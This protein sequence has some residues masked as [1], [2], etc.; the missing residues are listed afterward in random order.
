MYQQN[1]ARPQD[2]LLFFLSSSQLLFTALL[3]PHFLLRLTYPHGVCW[4]GIV[5]EKQGP[6]YIFKQHI[7]SF[8]YTAL[9]LV[10]LGCKQLHDIFAL[11]PPGFEAGLTVGRRPTR[12]PRYRILMFINA[13]A[14]ASMVLWIFYVWLTAAEGMAFLPYHISQKHKTMKARVWAL[15]G[16]GLLSVVWFPL[17]FVGIGLALIPMV[18]FLSFG[19][20]ANVKSVVWLFDRLA[21]I[22]PSIE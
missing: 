14:T 6:T 8:I 13:M 9:V 18:R 2:L 11:T 5:D 1:R 12:L 15:V 19:R 16:A 21:G 3:Y 17:L 7:P 20:T 22:G 10:Y 4:P